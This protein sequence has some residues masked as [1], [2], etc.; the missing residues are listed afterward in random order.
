MTTGG[1]CSA[2]GHKPNYEQVIGDLGLLDRLARFDPVVIGTPPLG[3]SVDNS[4]ID[5]ACSWPDLK[6]FSVTAARAFGSNENFSVSSE[7]IRGEP[8]SIASFRSHGWEIEVFCQNI[9][10]DQQWGVRHFR[11]ERRL[12]DIAPWLHA[13]VLDLK[14]SGVKTEPAFASAL[15]LAGDP[16]EAV[17]ELDRWSDAAL[18]DLVEGSRPRPDNNLHPVVPND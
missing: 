17:L 14:R 13:T 9:A 7:E 2:P 5:V 3:L 6:Q 8:S 11:V 1:E 4:D 12:L 10:T 15:G 18:R 16:Y